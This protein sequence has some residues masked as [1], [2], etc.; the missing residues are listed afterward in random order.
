VADI[1]I[2]I[3]YGDARGSTGR[4]EQKQPGS[5]TECGTKTGSLEFNYRRRSVEESRH[6]ETSLCFCFIRQGLRRPA[7]ILM[8][9][10]ANEN[11]LGPKRTPKWWQ[12]IESPSCTR[13]QHGVGPQK[14]YLVVLSLFQSQVYKM[15]MFQSLEDQVL[16]SEYKN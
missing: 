8:I 4:P 13:A 3:L 16:L 11:K 2:Y 10:T 12:V 6:L 1:Y 9:R 5:P 14:P 7:N 15:V